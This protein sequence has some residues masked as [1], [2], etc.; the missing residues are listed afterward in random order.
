MAVGRIILRHS[1]VR[2][3]ALLFRR[4]IALA[5][6]LILAVTA[7]SQSPAYP[8]IRVLG[9]ED[10]I[11]EQLSDSVESF[12]RGDQAGKA[13]SELSFYAYTPSEDIDLFTLA[14]AL[15]LPYDSPGHAESPDECR[16]DRQG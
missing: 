8:T 7:G 13:P 11:F 15:S 6:L 10:L 16:L 2:R 3:H 12:H 1:I 14:A 5:A 9:P 4:T